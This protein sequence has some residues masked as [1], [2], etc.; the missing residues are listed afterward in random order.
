VPDMYDPSLVTFDA[1]IDELRIAA[2]RQNPRALFASQTTRLR[3]LSDQ[4]NGFV[5]CPGDVASAP[6]L[7]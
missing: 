2:Y 7:R 3:K 4:L 5:H 6:R 1:P